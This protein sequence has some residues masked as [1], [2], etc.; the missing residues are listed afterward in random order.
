MI[1]KKIGANWVD[2][3]LI[4]AKRKLEPDRVVEFGSDEHLRIVRVLIDEGRQAVL[5]LR[6]GVVLDFEG[7]SV[8]VRDPDDET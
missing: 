6:G 2:A 8:L 5:A 4:S 7:K 3:R 1:V